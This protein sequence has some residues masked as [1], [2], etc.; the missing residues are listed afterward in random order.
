[1]LQALLASGALFSGIKAE[2]E[3]RAK[4]FAFMAVMA[5]IALLFLLVGLGALAAASALALAPHT[6]LPGAVA[7]VG[8]AAL[9]IALVFVMVGTHRKTA[10]AATAE[11]SSAAASDTAFPGLADAAG[12]APIPWLLGALALG[13]FLGRKS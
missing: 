2:V 7:I 11:T 8:G 3:A 5:V 13:V 12:Q 1:M 9:L 6:G 4:R 10:A